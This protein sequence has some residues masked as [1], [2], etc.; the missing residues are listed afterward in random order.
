MVQFEAK[1]FEL[2]PEEIPASLLDEVS[3]DWADILL[4]KREKIYNRIK[5]VIPDADAYKSR[6]CEPAIE[7][8]AN[9]LNLDIYKYRMSLLKYKIKIVKGAN[10]FIR[11]IEEAFKENG[12]FQ[13]GVTANKEKY[14]QNV[15][16][17]IRFTGDKNKVWG[18][19][20][21]FALA[22]YGN[23]TV[24]SKVISNVDVITG[25]PL[26]MFDEKHLARMVPAVVNLVI[27]GLVL[28]RM[29]IEAE[30]NVQNVL[31]LYND[32]LRPYVINSPFLN[33]KLHPEAC[34]IKLDYD[35]GQDRLYIYMKQELK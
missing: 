5:D 2:K 6:L 10:S 19:V 12:R 30:E 28:A 32:M 4:A 7:N 3:Q 1:F 8:F 29:C 25:E 23:K 15:I 35:S 26:P 18:C 14:K 34:L 17:T 11:N 9:V 16:Y 24:L 20:P 33:P 21:K 27:E 13:N 22:C 31:D